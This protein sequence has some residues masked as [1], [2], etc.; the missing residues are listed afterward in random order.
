MAAKSVL[1]APNQL[2]TPESLTYPL[3]ASLKYDGNRCLL[4]DGSFYSRTMKAQ[5]NR[6]LRDHLGELVNLAV[7]HQLIFDG[8]LWSPEIP[9]NELQSIIRA[10]DKPIPSHV[11]FYLFDMMDHEEWGC[12]DTPFI[13]RYHRLED[14]WAAH[15]PAHTKLVIQ[16][17][18]DNPGM[19]RGMYNVALA[20]GFEGVMLR[21]L[22]G[23]YKHGRATTKEGLIYKMKP[24]ETADAVIIGYEQQ[25]AVKDDAVRT[26]NE[27]GRTARTSKAEDHTLVDN[28]GAL[29]VRDEQGREF[30]LGWGKGW[31]I[32][33]RHQLWKSRASLIGQWVEYRYMAVGT[34]DLPRLPQLIRFRDSKS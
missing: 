4:M 2:P 10:E 13:D 25:K 18:V 3:M 21:S 6:N 32:S 8:E 11:Q 7:K 20:D 19:V 27:L 23:G 30:N 5:P 14:F 24:F 33:R 9:F 26:V 1:L 22:N 17:V 15:T 29:R 28:M 34:K 31:S 12:C 16:A